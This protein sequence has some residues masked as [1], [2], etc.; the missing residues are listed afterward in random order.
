MGRNYW[1]KWGT[2]IRKEWSDK[3]I[4]TGYKMDETKCGSCGKYIENPRVEK[5]KIVQKFCNTKC[6]D[7][8][9]NFPKKN[10]KQIHF[11]IREILRLV[12][13]N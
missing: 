6:H 7:A 9:H 11:H 4:Y 8:W 10:I 2:G 1:L 12:G 13:G 5:G 3:A